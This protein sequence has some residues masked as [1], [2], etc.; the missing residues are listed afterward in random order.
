MQQRNEAPSA[1]VVGVLA[2]LLTVWVFFPQGLGFP[3][4]QKGQKSAL[5]PGVPVQ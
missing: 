4:S 3:T 5:P 2:L 1:V